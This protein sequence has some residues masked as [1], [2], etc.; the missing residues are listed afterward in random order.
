[1]S[2]TA[3]E[4]PLQGGIANVGR[5]V[6]V[7]RTVRRPRRPTSEATR[8]LLDH[9]ERVGFEG[10]PRFLDFDDSGR[11]VL[12]FVVGDAAIA[13]HASWALTDDA[14]VS[15][16]HLLRRYH[17]AVS[18][19]DSSAHTWPVAVPHPYRSSIVSHN[20]PNLD[21]IVFRDGR[22]VALID[23]DLAGPGSRLWDIAAAARLWAPLRSEPDIT[24]A[25]RGRALHRLGAFLDAYG[26][27][28]IDPDQ[29]VDAVIANHDWLYDVVRDG[30]SVGNPGFTAYW[31]GGAE[32]RAERT[33]RWY[34]EHRSTLR[35]AVR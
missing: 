25:R 31:R 1:M 26:G 32:S 13:P 3:K 24:D 15:V 29:M 27:D 28:P 21:N 11:E 7:G 4:V 10:A 34:V 33:R 22:A 23:F 16:A 17:D 35:A 19:F 8:A 2:R 20:D 5:V 12:S 14:L 9:L 18:T 6:R 30:V